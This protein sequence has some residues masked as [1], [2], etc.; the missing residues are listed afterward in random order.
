MVWSSSAVAAVCLH[1]AISAAVPGEPQSW[2]SSLRLGSALPGTFDTTGVLLPSKLR[3]AVPRPPAL[4]PAVPLP[5]APESMPPAPLREEQQLSGA[6]PSFAEAQRDAEEIAVS[7]KSSTEDIGGTD[8]PQPTTQPPEQPQEQR[9]VE[10]DSP[11]PPPPPPWPTPT[12][13][14]QPSEPSAGLQSHRPPTAP[15]AAPTAAP[16]ASG[17][18]G[19][20]G[21]CARED[22]RAA[23]VLWSCIVTTARAKVH[24]A[25]GSALPVLKVP[26]GVKNLRVNI[27][28]A[29]VDLQ[30]ADL[31]GHQ[32]VGRKSS[33]NAGN[34]IGTFHGTTIHVPSGTGPRGMSF[35]GDVPAPLVLSLDNSLSQEVAAT[36]LHI[37]HDGLDP[38]PIKPVGCSPF[39]E[40]ETVAAVKAWSCKAGHNFATASNAWS[41]LGAPQATDVGVP[42]QRFG[43]IWEAF[44]KSPDQLDGETEWMS[45]FRYLDADDN[46]GISQQ[47]FEH[48]FHACSMSWDPQAMLKESEDYASKH[49]TMVGW[50]ACL[51]LFLVTVC[52]VFRLWWCQ[53][54]DERTMGRHSMEPPKIDRSVN[55]EKSAPGPPPIMSRREQPAQQVQQPPF[56]QDSGRSCGSWLNCAGFRAKLSGESQPPPMAPRPVQAPQAHQAQHAYQ[57]QHAQQ[58]QQALQSFQPPQ[59]HP[60][61]HQTNQTPSPLPAPVS[62]SQEEHDEREHLLQ[63]KDTPEHAPYHPHTEARQIQMTPYAQSVPERPEV[64]QLQLAPAAVPV[65]QHA[66]ESQPFLAAIEERQSTS[67]SAARQLPPLPATAAHA[68]PDPPSPPLSGMHLALFRLQ[69]ESDPRAHTQACRALAMQLDTEEK[70]HEACEAGVPEAIVR[71]MN[72]GRKDSSLQVAGCTALRCLCNSS[73]EENEVAAQTAAVGGTDAVLQAMREH[74]DKADVQEAACRAIR[75]LA[76]HAQNRLQICRCHGLETI[77]TSMRNHLDDAGVQESGCLALGNLAFEP[78]CRHAVSKGLIEAIVHGM[79]QHLPSLTVQEAG[80]FA[81]YNL[82]CTADCFDTIAECGGIEVVNMA[83]SQHP[84]LQESPEVHTILSVQ[85]YQGTLDG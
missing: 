21:V 37:E 85:P 49:V 15:P 22:Y 48:G 80:V 56:W 8:A 60:Q 12:A 4:R 31:Q 58:A 28:P 67:A 19:I 84:E 61:A 1:V 83:A 5:P 70:R 2:T 36:T 42:W 66:Q 78:E 18:P 20:G 68:D 7:S 69:N 16:L 77:R 64:P 38:C 54:R 65:T 29:T 76:L 75:H 11:P 34:P 25:G 44:G 74:P 10:V 63:H 72:H 53:D 9:T 26:A 43:G 50:F 27:T 47:E 55:F 6:T 45:A 46:M 23:L 30:V 17:W 57:T 62:R 40:E 33:I 71:V 41:A 24:I 39:Y 35:D 81:M 82:I 13:T 51:L 59:P 52:C 73:S 3:P 14:Q 79:H 32:I